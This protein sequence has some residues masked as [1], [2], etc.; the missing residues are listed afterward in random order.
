MTKLC[1]DLCARRSGTPA[2][3]E[4]AKKRSSAS[5][6]FWGAGEGSGPARA[7]GA[8]P[9]LSGR[10]GQGRKSPPAG[11][12]KG[13]GK[14]YQKSAAEEDFWGG[15][16]R[17]G[18]SAAAKATTTPAPNPTPAALAPTRAAATS[19]QNR[20][21]GNT[22]GGGKSS[23]LTAKP[24][25]PAVAASSYVQPPAAAPAS[26]VSKP[27][28]RNAGQGK[29][30]E[31]GRVGGAAGTPKQAVAVAVAEPTPQW[32]GVS[33]QC[34]GKTHDVITNCTTCGKIACVEEG[35]FGCSF[36]AAVLPRTGR[37]PKSL[38]GDD[39]KGMGA[40]GGAAPSAALKE[41]LERKDKLL[42]FDR[43]SAS[44]TRVLDDQGDYFTSN[45]WLSQRERESGEAEE[46]ARRDEAAQRRGARR[47]VKLSIDIMGRRVIET[48][49]AGASGG[50]ERSDEVAAATE[51]IS[52][53]F[54]ANARGSSGGIG[55]SVGGANTIA[56]EQESPAGSDQ[57][58][59]QRP[60]LENTGLRGRAKEV[61]DVMR[62]NLD[63]QRRRQPGGRG[64]KGSRIAGGEG[65]RA[66][67]SRVSLWRVQHDVES[68]DV[69][70]RSQPGADG[71]SVGGFVPDGLDKFQPRDE[72]SC[73]S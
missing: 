17:S 14:M 11:R 13:K 41:A 40:S 67:K 59:D 39:S 31:G 24:K 12:G 55:G 72:L 64:S 26:N 48:R 62:A 60:S 65:G 3:A 53:N 73:A 6:D 32:S 36:C 22:K 28:S 8:P 16:T 37:E 20:S 57:A 21:K 66:E 71:G 27:N 38:R 4:A 30:S 18:R 56:T 51:G 7:A 68:E 69:V 58:E 29:A 1:D 42:L 70:R 34:M 2:A 9:A 43:T 33:C 54:G 10:E 5:D 63:K 15:G 46:K 61:Y 19:T 47:E 52:L 35:G 45:N 25:P 49:D 23:T 44:R 50:Q